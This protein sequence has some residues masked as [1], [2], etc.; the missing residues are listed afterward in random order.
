[1]TR[2]NSDRCRII[3]ELVAKGLSR[4][5]SEK[6]FQAVFEVM[7]RALARGEEVELPVG[8]LLVKKSSRSREQRIRKM[9]KLDGTTKYGLV[10]IYK[11]KKTVVFKPAKDFRWE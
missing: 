1:M 5:K 2:S 11:R 4:R 10:A 9:H 3:D 8:D 6:G 7:K